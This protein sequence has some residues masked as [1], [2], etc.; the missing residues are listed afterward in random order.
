MYKYL[1]IAYLFLNWI[2]LLLD[3]F[4]VLQMCI[5]KY[6]FIHIDVHRDLN[7]VNII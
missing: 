3:I 6:I 2:D 1:N 5:F 4:C 7:V